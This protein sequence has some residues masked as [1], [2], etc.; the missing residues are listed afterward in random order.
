MAY[1]NYHKLITVFFP[2]GFGHS[3]ESFSALHTVLPNQN[4][5]LFHFCF[6]VACLILPAALLPGQYCGIPQV[7]WPCI[8]EDLYYLVLFWFFLS[9]PVK[10]AWCCWA[11]FQI[12]I[13]FPFPREGDPA[14]KTSQ[15]ETESVTQARGVIDQVSNQQGHAT[16][17]QVNPVIKGYHPPSEAVADQ[18]SIKIWNL[19]FLANTPLLVFN[20]LDNLR[21]YLIWF[22]KN[23]LN[24]QG[25]PI[26]IEPHF[27]H[28]CT[29]HRK[30]LCDQR[31]LGNS[32]LNRAHQ[33]SLLQ[34]FRFLHVVKDTMNLWQEIENRVF[35]ALLTTEAIFWMEDHSVGPV[36]HRSI[37]LHHLSK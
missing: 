31:G 1:T 19:P 17:P 20:F 7:K 32:G 23:I 12:I 2:F 33:V 6:V 37:F 9:N 3:S 5:P 30:G 28:S 27:P 26:A 25:Q 35:P 22:F 14:G 11:S 29:F 10:W 24:N 15:T 36:S 34:A 8:C 13:Q 4:K 21:F 16:F 18:N